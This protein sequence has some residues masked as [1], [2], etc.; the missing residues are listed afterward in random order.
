MLPGEAEL[1]TYS[2]AEPDTL[3]EHYGSA[4]ITNDGCELL[5]ALD[6]VEE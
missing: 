3:C 2:S 4:K 1:P 5:A 6:A